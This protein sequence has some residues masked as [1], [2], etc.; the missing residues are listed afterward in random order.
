M[1]NQPTGKTYFI[2]KQRCY[3]SLP[4]NPSLTSQDK[5][6]TFSNLHNLYLMTFYP[7]LYVNNFH[8]I[9]IKS[10]K[11]PAQQIFQYT[12]V[13]RRHGAVGSASHS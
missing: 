4:F 5:T 8:D 6:R 2:K 3:C 7:T 1:K 13:E 11:I 10:S 9:H 12:I